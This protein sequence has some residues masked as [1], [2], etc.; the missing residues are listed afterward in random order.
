MFPKNM[1][2]TISDVILKFHDPLVQREADFSRPELDS[3]RYASPQT[4]SRIRNDFL[5][6]G[7][8]CG[9][10][11]LLSDVFDRPT[12]VTENAVSAF[13]F[14]VHLVIVRSTSQDR[15]V[16]TGVSIRNENERT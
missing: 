3:A 14:H 9:H 5:E 12:V 11:F 1:T 10:S 13:H 2:W 7:G 16:G 6:L 8:Y 4:R 15:F